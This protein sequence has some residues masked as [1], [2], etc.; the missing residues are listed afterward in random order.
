LILFGTF[1]EIALSLDLGLIGKF[2]S[3]LNKNKKN[4]IIN[5][6]QEIFDP[7]HQFFQKLQQQT[8]NALKWTIVWILLIGIF[9]L[10][11]YFNI[12]YEKCLNL[13]LH[14]LLRKV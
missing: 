13:L 8:R 7:T 9:A 4:L 3:L 14:P 11:V 6:N 2:K 10:I 5:Q 1:V 12:G